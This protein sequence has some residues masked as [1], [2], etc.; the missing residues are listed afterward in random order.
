MWILFTF[1]SLPSYENDFLS[2]GIMGL[3][4]DFSEKGKWWKID[5]DGF[6]YDSSVILARNEIPSLNSDGVSYQIIS[7]E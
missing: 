7:E 5:I 2:T 3:I 6:H 1:M 4:N